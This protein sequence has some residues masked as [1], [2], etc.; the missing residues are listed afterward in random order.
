MMRPTFRLQ[1][2]KNW[3]VNITPS[4]V[5]SLPYSKIKSLSHKYRQ[6][7]L[8]SRTAP[9]APKTLGMPP[10][11]IFI[12]QPTPS[13]VLSPQLAAKLTRSD[14]SSLTSNLRVYES[15]PTR[16]P[17]IDEV[18]WEVEERDCT[19]E[20]FI[21]KDLGGDQALYYGHGQFHVLGMLD[22]DRAEAKNN[23]LFDSS[24]DL[25]SRLVEEVGQ[26][27]PSSDLTVANSLDGRESWI[28]CNTG[29]EQQK[30]ARV[31]TDVDHSDGIATTSVTLN[32]TL[33]VQGLDPDRTCPHL[34]LAAAGIK[35]GPFTSIWA[36]R[37]T[38]ASDQSRMAGTV[39]P[40]SLCVYGL[41]DAAR[42]A[43]G[44]AYTIL[45]VDPT[46]AFGER[47]PDLE[48]DEAAE[49]WLADHGF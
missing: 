46:R 23:I 48:P 21:D 10:A 40:Q 12:C 26:E 3:I 2:I 49:A 45:H 36:R 27:L 1:H 24:D 31:V 33:P 20:Y 44:L 41:L 6:R 9:V 22:M 18:C 7:L 19:P 35:T 17:D 25:L 32:L 30:V 16:D 28:L 4:R 47:D 11:S 14:I 8:A 38:P 34:R 37:G 13:Y 43:M 5:D 29:E 42:R 15:V 39:S